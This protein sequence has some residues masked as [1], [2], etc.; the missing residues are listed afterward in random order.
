MNR[1]RNAI[2]IVAALLVVVVF[3][4]VAG[5]HGDSSAIP[6][7]LETVKYTAFTVKLP[8]NGVVMNST[9]VTV[10]TL[11][12]G[13]VGQIFVKPGMHV[14]AGELLATIENPTLE[15]NAASSQADYTN[16]SA[17]V[18]TARVQE[19]N[20][21]VQYQAQVD[22]NKSALD[23]ARRVYSADVALLA[24]KAIAQSQVDADRAKLEQAQVAYDQAVQQLK[25]GAVSGYGMD[26]VQA[27]QANAEKTKIINQQNQQQVAFT[28]IVAP[29]SGI[30]ETV[31]AQSSNALRSLQP[32]DAVTAGQTLFTLAAD[33]QYVVKAQ[34]DEQDIINV[35]VGQAANVT[36]QD[37][38]GH[39]IPGHVIRIDPV[40][41]KS[42]DASS[43]AMQVLTTIA[44][45][46]SPPYL[47]DGMSADVD[48][49]TSDIP[50]AISIP[51]AA[52]S[53]TG[54]ASYVYVAKAGV[55]R[56]RTIVPG[57]TGDSTTLVTSGLAPGEVIVAAKTPDLI[58][59]SRVTPMPSP[60][61]SP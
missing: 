49:I 41:Q 59:G 32:G 12:G 15:Y 33:N 61:S 21:R 13:N 35:H 47:K 4:I 31:A 30:L 19:Q 24:Q 44:L 45:D 6:A 38:P 29:M 16:A 5:R 40:A 58:D 56:K 7:K 3:A 11:V 34:V 25:L 22:T 27:A 53:K 26:S 51:T 50:H 52:I 28:R 57:R 43:T 54:S 36:G 60:S 39:V 17:N 18:A 8:E 10:P 9:T 55:A 48:I 42:T 20:A 46:S 1:T 2:I 37:F 14:N 23:E